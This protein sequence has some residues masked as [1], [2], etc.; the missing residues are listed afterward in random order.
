MY[1]SLSMF[2]RYFYVAFAMAVLLSVVY[3]V[4][5]QLKNK[6]TVMNIG[7]RAIKARKERNKN[8]IMGLFDTKKEV[9]NDDIQGLLNVSHATAFRYLNELEKE[10][11]V[12]K[13][14]DTGRGVFYTK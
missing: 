8:K 2:N 6:N 12:K 13:H 3:F 11:K 7:I 10:K 1:M 9:T 4:W 14:G 5:R